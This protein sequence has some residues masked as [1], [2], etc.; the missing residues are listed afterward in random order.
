[1]GI[2]GAASGTVVNLDDRIPIVLDGAGWGRR[3]GFARMS[4]MLSQW[5]SWTVALAL[6][7][8]YHC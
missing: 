1:M 8:G 2:V 7:Y 5:G 3:V 6:G 4:A